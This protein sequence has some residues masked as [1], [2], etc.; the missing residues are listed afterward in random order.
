VTRKG[1]ASDPVA[2]LLAAIPVLAGR[3][4]TPKDRERFARYLTLLLE[5]NRVHDL[6]S[7]K[8]PREVVRGLFIDSL[9]FLPQLP[10]R[11][12]RLLDIGSGAG[13]PGLPLHLLDA[14]ISVA[15]LEARRKRVSFLAMVRRE[16]GLNGVEILE[17]RAEQVLADR[18]DLKGRFDAVTARGVAPSTDFLLTCLDYVRVGGRVIISGPPA[19][20]KSGPLPHLRGRWVKGSFPIPGLNRWFFLVEREA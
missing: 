12:I 11:P 5:W 19:P 6:T 4:A 10:P 2:E 7:H 17:G 15:L 9:L 8:Q 13:I 1:S 3:P 20:P 14:D 18:P 16:L